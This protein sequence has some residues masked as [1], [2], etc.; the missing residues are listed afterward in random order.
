MFWSLKLLSNFKIL[1]FLETFK[2]LISKN[3]TD[4]IPLPDYFWQWYTAA[5]RRVL[6]FIGLIPLIFY[7]FFLVYLKF[8]E[9]QMFTYL[10]CLR[11]TEILITYCGISNKENKFFQSNWNI[12][13]HSGKRRWNKFWFFSMKCFLGSSFDDICSSIMSGEL[14]FIYRV[15][16]QN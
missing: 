9:L 16:W 1:G 8:Y 13:Q 6:L 3:W 2:S 5:L 10:H 15:L 11:V 12:A 7:C 4:Y 14:K